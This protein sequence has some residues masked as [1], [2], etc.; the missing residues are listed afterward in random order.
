MN[1]NIIKEIEELKKVIKKIEN[2]CIW[3]YIGIG[4]GVVLAV[5]A[6]LYYM[7]NPDLIKGCV[8][9]LFIGGVVFLINYISLKQRKKRIEELSIDLKKME[10][11]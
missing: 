9:I 8:S 1:E 10:E 3:S 7:I 4:I 2:K 11:L 5:Y 6:L